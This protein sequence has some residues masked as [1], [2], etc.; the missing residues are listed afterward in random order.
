MPVMKS[1]LILYGSILRVNVCLPQACGHLPFLTPVIS[2]DKLAAQCNN[3]N[4]KEV[5]GRGQCDTDVQRVT[6]FFNIRI[7]HHLTSKV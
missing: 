6:L 1:V 2:I 4:M 5:N 3:Q 7:Q